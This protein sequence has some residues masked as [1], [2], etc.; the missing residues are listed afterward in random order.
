MKR[1]L[2]GT[3]LLA[4]STF[5]LPLAAL[6]DEQPSRAERMHRMA[7]D[8]EIMMHARLAGMKAGLS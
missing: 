8:R 3:L 4:A 1:I 5:A 7:A 2:L 6:S